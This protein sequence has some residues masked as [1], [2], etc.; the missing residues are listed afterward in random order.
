[1]KFIEVIIKVY[2]KIYVILYFDYLI[3]FFIL[4]IRCFENIDKLLFLGGIMIKYCKI[5][6]LGNEILYNDIVIFIWYRL[7]FNGFV[8]WFI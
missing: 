7:F 5:L 4:F 8:F 2:L 1:M 6:W 3:M